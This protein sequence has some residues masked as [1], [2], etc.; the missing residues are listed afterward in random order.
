MNGLISLERKR[1]HKAV[2]E[3][4]I[5]V[6]KGIPNFADKD[7]KSSREIA[8]T[9]VKLLGVAKESIKGAG[10]TSGSD[11]EEMCAKFISDTFLK[12]KVLRPGKWEIRKVGSRSG[13]GIS[14]FEQYSHLAD[15][16]KL[17]EENATLAAVLGN[18]YT[19]S[20]DIVLLREPEEDAFI[21][22]KIKIVDN[23]SARYSPLRK[24]NSSKVILH[25]SISCKWTLRSDRAQ[26]ARAEALNLMRN[27]KGRCPHIIVITAEPLPSRLSS[28][29]LGTGDIDCVYHFALSELIEAV[30]VFGNEEALSMLNIMIDGKR[31]KD[32]SDLPLDLCV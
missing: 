13:A 10:Q 5:T 22:E 1:F 17:S 7:S 9:I 27:R 8:K 21:N 2:L 24:S 19:I 6:D 30:K 11:F 26:N 15:L 32:I 20:P 29:A 4:L 16:K 14:S 31:L 23:Q 3:K 28:L 12:L 25:A 18:D